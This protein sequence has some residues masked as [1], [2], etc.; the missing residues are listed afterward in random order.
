MSRAPHFYVSVFT[1]NKKTEIYVKNLQLR[2]LHAILKIL[3]TLRGPTASLIHWDE[4]QWVENSA[5][6]TFR[7]TAESY[8]GTAVTGRNILSALGVNWYFKFFPT[9][10]ERRKRLQAQKNAEKEDAEDKQTQ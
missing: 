1:E 7:Y 10:A 2:K 5:T 8:E 3:P 9:R 4:Q 6:G